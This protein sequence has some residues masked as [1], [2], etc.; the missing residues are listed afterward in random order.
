MKR[1][2]ILFSGTSHTF[3]LGLEIEFRPKYN[4]DE[5]LK[6]NGLILPLP[7]EPEDEYYWKNY[8][9][10][11]LVC[12]EF[13]MIEFNTFDLDSE[14]RISCN[15]IEFLYFMHSDKELGKYLLDVKYVV[16]E[17]PGYLRWWD[18]ELHGKDEKKYP[19]TIREVVNFIENSNEDFQERIK[20]IQWLD[21]ADYPRY[22]SIALKKYFEL[23]SEYKDVI[24]MLLPWSLPFDQKNDLGKYYV[25]EELVDLNGFQSV[26]DYLS[27]NKCHIY[28][29]CK[30]FN[31]NY[32]YTL[33]DDHAN[34]EGHKWVAS[35]VVNHIRNKFYTEENSKFKGMDLL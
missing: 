18:K 25:E 11:K 15:G 21:E 28:D 24:F 27:V 1:N 7:R 29:S 9:W 4:D 31:G 19:N 32:K 20:A 5:W 3:G 26:S 13:N 22:I 35:K 6:K 12:D 16:I 33:K 14:P 17:F 34:S 8:R 23:K 30:A 2:K 10:P